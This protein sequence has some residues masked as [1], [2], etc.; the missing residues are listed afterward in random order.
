MN[1]ENIRFIEYEE[2]ECN[3]NISEAPKE[4]AP[5]ANNEIPKE[6]KV[7]VPVVDF[8]EPPAPSNKKATKKKFEFPQTKKPN[9]TL[10]SIPQS[11]PVGP[12]P[13]APK[14]KPGRKNI[15]IEI[16]NQDFTFSKKTDE[17]MD[18]IPRSEEN[19]KLDKAISPRKM[20]DDILKKVFQ[21]VEENQKLN[22]RLT[23]LET[24]LSGRDALVKSLTKAIEE[25]GSNL[26]RLLVNQ[27]EASK[28]EERFNIE[29]QSRQEEINFLKIALEKQKTK[30]KLL[31]NSM[32][33]KDEALSQL[34]SYVQHQM[35]EKNLQKELKAKEQFNRLEELT[36]AVQDMR[37][38][39]RE[40]D[41]TLIQLRN[42]VEQLS[43]QL[44][45]RDQE[46]ADLRTS[47][48]GNTSS[49]IEIQG[50]R[51]EKTKTIHA[52]A[53]QTDERKYGKGINKLY[54]GVFY[55]IERK[56][57]PDSK[58][59]RRQTPSLD[60]NLSAPLTRPTLTLEEDFSR[61]TLLES[62]KNFRGNMTSV[63][64][65]APTKKV[66][67]DRRDQIEDLKNKYHEL[68]RSFRN[69]SNDVNSLS[70]SIPKTAY[71]FLGNQK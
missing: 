35:N 5:S 38:K 1:N 14:S 17:P 62:S 71:F 33:E 10:S 47:A 12:I 58:D 40:K 16:P 20:D 34:K 37:S 11:D 42:K 66:F 67:E 70:F 23:E 8:K 30:K 55:G 28:A 9:L 26:R 52:E 68:R 24:N 6:E 59:P 45:A 63:A 60:K 7:D 54:S 46:L 25:Q 29:L 13:A 15:S 57:S 51:L 61:K 48:L 65:A 2:F 32:K 19:T 49:T 64:A 27:E 22:K 39:L 36:F 43:K 21:L 41:D 69:K 56:G 18:S 50:N 31:T 44:A 4:E 3:P 53:K